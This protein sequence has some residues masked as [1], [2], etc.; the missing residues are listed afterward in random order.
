MATLTELLKNLTPEQQHYIARLVASLP[1]TEGGLNLPLSNTAMDRAKAMG[2]VDVYHGTAHDIR[3]IDPKLFGASTGA[4]SAKKAFWT[5]SDPNTARGYAEYAARDVPIKKLLALAEKA[6]KKGDWDLYDDYI[7]QAEEYEAAM[8]KEPLAG[9]NIMPLMQ[10][11]SKK[12]TK[13]FGGAEF[14]D[15]QQDIH[16]YLNKAKSSGASEAVLENLAD[17]VYFSGRPATHYA[18]FKPET[19]RSRFAAFNPWRKGE[20]DLLASHPLASAGAALAATGGLSGMARDYLGQP[21]DPG[22]LY[23]QYG[24]DAPMTRGEA[25]KGAVSAMPG[26]GEVLSGVEG[27]QAATE[28]K[29]GEAGLGALGAA[30][31]APMGGVA[32]MIRASHGSPHA[33]T[34]F[35]FSK[36]GTGEGAQAYGYGGYFAQGFD[37]PVAKE[38]RDKLSTGNNYVNKELIDTYNPLH[39]LA[40]ALDQESGNLSETLGY[41]DMMAARGNSKSIKD[42]AKAA[43]ELFNKGERPL[44]EYIKPE[45]HLYNVEL[46]W[47]DAAR[48]AADPLGEHHLLDWDVTLANQPEAIKSALS[49]LEA[50]GTGFTYGDI[51]QSLEAAPHL[52]DVNEY[53]WAHP[54]GK[55]IYSSLGESMMVGNKAPGQYQA[56][57]K[58][59][60]LGIPGIRYLDQASRDAGTGTRNYVMFDDRFPNIVSRNGVSLADLLRK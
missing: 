21:H 34:K 17:D 41:L 55:D 40:S 6:E 8:A 16:K 59:R 47:P 31:L 13:D 25:L 48:E 51:L 28:G 2:G 44:L 49:K 9:Q 18:T 42:T 15:V 1:E 24:M 29:W 23:A 10:L 38:Y 19:L 3:N 36:I 60:D 56:S 57:N 39:F 20:A 30:G 32:G 54:T 45:G 14:T 4:E 50:P 33:H 52:N 53:S 7:R 37:S 22:N 5:V 35:D 11:G 46:K 26:I 27:L 58:L 43:I 12:L